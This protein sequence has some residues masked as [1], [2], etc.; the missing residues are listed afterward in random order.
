MRTLF[1]D[2]RAAVLVA[3]LVPVQWVSAQVISPADTP[4]ALSIHATRAL[5]GKHFDATFYR[6]DLDVRFNPDYLYGQTRVEGRVTDEPINELA[7]D[8]ASTGIRVDRVSSGGV[9]LGYRHQNDLLYIDLAKTY[10]VGETVRLDIAYQGVPTGAGF[11]SDAFVFGTRAGSPFA[12]TRSEPYGARAWW[13]NKDHPSDKADSVRV[14]VTVPKPLRVGSNGLL[15]RTTETATTT[16]Y[17]WFSRYPIATYLVSIAVGRYEVFEQ[18]YTRPDTLAG[19]Y[20]AAS[21][22]ILHYQ[23]QGS[24]M[25]ESADPYRGWNRVIDMMPVM[26]YWFGPYP[27]AGEKYGHSE[28]TFGGGMEH[29]TMTSLGGNGVSLVS[30]ELAHQWFGDLITMETWP[31]LWLNEGFA[32]YAELLYWEARPDLYPGQFRAALLADM[33]SARNAEGT[34]LVQGADTLSTGILFN[35]NRVYAKGGIVLHMLRGIVG[36]DAF[37][38]ILQTYV[39]DP[40]FR[41][42]NADTDDFRRVAEQVSGRDLGVFFRQW[43]TEG[44]GEPVFAVTWTSTPTVEGYAVAGT[45]RQTQTPSESNV[46]V[47]EMPAEIAVQTTAGE[48]R[49]TVEID[50]RE[51]AFRF[52]IPEEPLTLTFDPDYRIL[53]NPNVPVGAETP[54]LPEATGLLNVFPNPASERVYLEFGLAATGTVRIEVFDALGRRV[55]EPLNDRFAAGIHVP[56]FSVGALPAGRYFIR[57]SCE[58]AGTWTRPLLIVHNR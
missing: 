3:A 46:A 1:S 14:V 53:R 24:G 28:T 56:D 18:T 30:H 47:F 48:R 5:S 40:A 43:V 16:T 13:P 7:L 21:F 29:Q 35:G 22:P 50:E 4:H 8:L 12:W 15:V 2:F 32:T 55:L 45:I 36:D 41:Y 51:E 11:Y 26:E 49:F 38:R 42:G 23:Y 17:E 10:A 44:T 39:A 33:R 6:L 58:G 25:Y 20:G 31:H 52:A 34:L 9:S 57:M 54:D 27:F 19:M 37:R